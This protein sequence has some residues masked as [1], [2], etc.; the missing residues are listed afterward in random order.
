ML[1]LYYQFFSKVRD[2]NKSQL[3]EI[4]TDSLYFSLAEEEL[5]DCFRTEMKAEWEKLRLKNCTDRLNGDPVGIFPPNLLCQ[6][7]ETW[8]AKAWF[9]QKGVQMCKD[10]M[11]T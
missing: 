10:V 9:L 4:H 6:T 7:Y 8:Q 11:L 2:K 3:L 5:E 1:E